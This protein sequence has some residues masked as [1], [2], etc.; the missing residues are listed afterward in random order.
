MPDLKTDDF[1]LL[2][3]Q[4]HSAPRGERWSEPVRAPEHPGLAISTLRIVRGI[5]LV[6]NQLHGEG[7]SGCYR[8][9]LIFHLHFELAV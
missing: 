9:D 1:R 7:G 2:S 5:A 4:L 3:N 8:M 6:L